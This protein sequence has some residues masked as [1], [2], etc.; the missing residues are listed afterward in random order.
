MKNMLKRQLITTV[1][2]FIS[3]LLIAGGVGSALHDF[4]QIKKETTV[5]NQTIASS[6]TVRFDNRVESWMWAKNAGGPSSDYGVGVAVDENGDVYITGYF[7]GTA[8]FGTIVL[9]SQ[10]SEDVFVAKLTRKGVWQWAVRGGGTSYDYGYGIGVADDLYITGTFRGSATFG[11]TTLVS[12]GSNDIFIAKLSTNGTWQWAV[13]GGGDSYDYTDNVAVDENGSISI[14]GFFQDS[15]TFGNTTL[16]SQGGND[17]FIAKL[18]TNG[19][20]QWAVRGGGISNEWGYSTAVDENGS[21]Y[22]TG[23]FQGTATFGTTT[24]LSQGSDDVLLAKLTM[25]GTWQWAVSAG[26]ALSDY[27]YGVAVDENGSAYITGYFQGNATFGTIPLTGQGGNDIFV[28]SVNT[29][30]GWQWTVSAGGAYSDYGNDLAVDGEGN[31]RVIGDFEGT[32]TFGNNTLT[33]QG[34][35]DIFAAKLATNGTWLWIVS[36][37]GTFRD[38]GN[39]I[40]VV[41]NGNI[42]I[43]GNFEGTA[44]FG[45][46][47][48]VSKGQTDMFITQYGKHPPVADFA[49]TPDKPSSNEKITFNASASQDPLGTII[50]YE[51]DWDNDGTF[52]ESHT[53]PTATHSWPAA[54]GYPVTLRVTDND[55]LTDSITKT[56]TVGGPNQ[57]PSPPTI[58]GPAQ[59]KIKIATEYNFTTIDPEGDEVYYYIDWGD[60]T[61]SGW[62][63]PFSSGDVVNKSHTWSKKG[64]Y[65]IRA[66]AKDVHGNE[67][68]WG[69]LSV[70]M[71]YSL[72]VPLQWFWEILFERFPNAFPIL[73]HFVGY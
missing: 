25:N 71:P 48:L 30:G 41:E 64:T 5:T 60:Q 18:S 29:T 8:M 45:N 9:T 42:C 26:G 17:I 66:K 31:V 37:G 55:Q 59:G 15:A 61:N 35:S 69:T 32:A 40:T 46:I 21:V 27:G 12:Q 52:N 62:L 65:T 34:N 33:S 1:S 63:G 20:W 49:W 23:I 58:T 36:A 72:N 47:T 14:T 44:T 57:P 6:Q 56:V 7:Q 73:R 68:G 16:I 10:G 28:A 67:S 54:G 22:L 50:L 70:T 13:R 39:D 53:V 38:N 51:W 2:L 24:L 3:T 4:E 11:N 43:T 19:T